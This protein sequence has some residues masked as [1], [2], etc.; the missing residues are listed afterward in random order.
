MALLDATGRARV[1]AQ[2]MRENVISCAFTK[3]DLVAAVA[4]ADQWVEDNAVSYNQALPQPF[5][6]SATAE[7]K[8]AILAYVL[9]RRIGRLRARED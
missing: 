2:W 8:I 9:W 1:A 5:R 7:Q 6:S 3:P 4:A